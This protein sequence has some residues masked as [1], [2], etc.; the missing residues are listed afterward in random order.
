[1]LIAVAGSV[2]ATA[3]DRAGT[4]DFTATLSFAFAV[5]AVAVT[6]AVIILVVPDNR[7]GWLLVT[8]A[9]VMGAG[10]ACLEAGVHG[11]VTA[12]GS[13]P[14]AGYLAGFGPG[15]EAAGMLIAVIGVPVVFP[16]GRLPGPRWRWLAWCVAAAV[17]CLFLGNVL[18]P[19][20]Q[21]SRLAHWQNPVGLPS[22]DAVIANLLS[23]G[24]VLL[25]VV[26]A[27]GAI[28][29][30]V[31]RWRRGGPFVRQQLLFLA[32]AAIPPAVVFV[33][34]IVTNSV[35]GWI[36][37]AVLLPLPA[38]ISVATLSHGLYDLRRA[39]QRTLLW[40]TMSGCVAGVYAVVVVAAASLIHG[41][42]T[43]WPSALAAAAAALL[44][45]PLR[46]KLQ[47]GVT[48]LVY[49]RW[50]EPYEVLA[51][52]GEN[53]EAAA[54]IDRLLA[55]VVA[56][57]GTG[58]DLRDVSVRDV[59]G[60]MVTGVVTGVLNGQGDGAGE[61]GGTP[62]G[63]AL[64]GDGGGT[65]IA[66][67]AY[68]VRVGWLTYRAPERPLS[69]AE[70]RLMRDL[71]RQLGGVLHARMLRAD[72]QRARERLVL[73]REEERRRLRRDLHDGIGPALAGLTLKAET[74]RAL[75]PPGTGAAS[76]QLHDLGE[77]IRGMVVDVRRLVEGLRPPALDELGLAGACAQAVG[78]L[79]AGAAAGLSVSVA[80]SDDLPALPAAVEVAAYRIVV[81]AV[82]NTV[83]HAGARR[84]QV[85]MAM[86]AGLAASPAVL[87]L[88]VTDDGTGLPPAGHDGPGHGLAIMRERAE[89]LGGAV[90]ITNGSPGVT[91]RAWLPAMPSPAPVAVAATAT[92]A[93]AV[94]A[95]ER[96]TA[97]PEAP[98]VPAV[99]G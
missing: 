89:E 6:G 29:G 91:V 10:V 11:V 98:R 25:A 33:V 72:L 62:G 71:A 53:L 31:T 64:E 95:E 84:C 97:Q 39:A 16:D 87:A 32:L 44:L 63:G 80:A 61:G 54:D 49:G 90:T 5:G 82:T 13:V 21:Q 48:R 50:H 47:R 66:V 27:A 60:A 57:L 14:G 88:A 38:A 17:T 58:L 86:G 52:L 22:R 12:P 9:A 67:L 56:E 15:L 43:W 96:E 41:R 4:G 37:G 85:S 99:P 55:A 40:L 1:V 81:E 3:Y 78:R 28:A 94:T 45:V 19:H 26:A 76:Q 24:G 75:L 46:E 34:V 68:G 36:F 69:S 23:T 7:V 8:A 92:A 42:H 51:G 77:E 83:R 73:A 18:S 30:L 59:D 2:I 74:A 20:A 93:V 70:Q 65:G 35:P 79:T